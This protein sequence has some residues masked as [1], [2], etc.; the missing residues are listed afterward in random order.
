[1]ER[2]CLMPDA[3]R[4]EKE[5]VNGEIV[6]ENMH[7]RKALM[8]SHA[9]CFVAL[10]GGLGTLEELA[11]MGTWLTLGMSSKPVGILNTAGFYD[12]LLAMFDKAHASGFQSWSSSSEKS[13]YVVRSDPVELLDALQAA[14]QQRAAAAAPAEAAV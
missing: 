5:A 7:Q 10:P 6:V 12:P 4:R 9:S 14:I 11:E 13:P 2:P 8:A 3:T 1:M